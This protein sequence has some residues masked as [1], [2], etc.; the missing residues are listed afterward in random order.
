M[1][2]LNECSIQKLLF[3]AV[4]SL[5]FLA[6]FFSDATSKYRFYSKIAFSSRLWG[7]GF[8]LLSFPM[9]NLN[10]GSIQKLLFAA[11]C[12]VLVFGCFL[13]QFKT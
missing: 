1:Q 5:R 2:N 12:E 3:L 9:Q 13:F 11:V 8:W 10:T 7:F 6:A 4:C